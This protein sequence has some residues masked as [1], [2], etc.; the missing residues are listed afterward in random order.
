MSKIHFITFGCALNQ[1]D[2]EMMMG[3]I[4]KAG[5]SIVNST[6]LADLVVINSCTVKHLAEK[7]LFRAVR[8]SDKRG[9]KIVVAGC[10]VQAEKGYAESKLN[11]YSIIG[12]KQL[13]RIVYVVEE[14]LKG[15]TVHLLDNAVNQRFNISKVRRNRIIGIIPISEGCLGECTYCKAR[16]ARGSLVSYS[17]DAIID[18]IKSDVN[19]GCKEI[20]LTSQDCGAYG[21][22]IGTEI[23]A[24]LCKVVSIDGKFM[25]RL[26]MMNPNFAL[27]HLD[28]L[29]Q[30]YNNNKDRLF[31]F[32]HIPVQA[33]S[34]R[35]LTLMKRKYTSADYIH[36]C[37]ALRKAMPDIT[38]ATDIICGFPTETEQEFQQSIELIHKTMPDVIN[39]SRFWPRPG[40]PAAEMSGKVIGR[41][42]NKRS[43]L[44]RDVLKRV[45]LRRNQDIWNNWQGKIIIDEKGSADSWIGRNYAYKPVAITT[46]SSI[47]KQHNV[48]VKKV[49]SYH[50]EAEIC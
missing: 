32:I 43:R 13:N 34:N 3:L 7:K 42:T 35:I 24:L 39:I 46:Q 17:I 8:D 26:G 28:D 33:G 41:D 25:V 47:G 29:I 2:S 19:D 16:F 6:D 40:T 44:M 9:L 23:I 14:T 38:I 37:Q 18:Q 11:D 30:I 50:L 36:I 21:R 22:D 1:A 10:V 31:R 45:S 4:E 5:H 27:E 49:F 15:N 48:K 12:T 20:W